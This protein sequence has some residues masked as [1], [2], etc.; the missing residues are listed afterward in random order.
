MAE[1]EQEPKSESPSIKAGDIE[2]RLTKSVLP[3]H[4]WIGVLTQ[5]GNSAT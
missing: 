3:H 1:L 5:N 4:F 2:V